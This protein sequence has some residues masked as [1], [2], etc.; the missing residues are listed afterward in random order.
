MMGV[1]ILVTGGAGFIGSH[2]ADALLREG[3]HV[4]VLDDFSTGR[5]ANLPD[6]HERLE[7][8]RGC[9]TDAPG[10]RDACAGVDGVVHLAA[11]ASVQ[12]SVDDPVHTHEVNFRGTLNV[13]EGM[14]AAGAR[15][16]VYASSAAVYGNRCAPPVAEDITLQPLTPYASDKLAGEHYAEFYAREFGLEPGVFRFFNVY[17]PRQ[18]PGS[19][20][21]GVISIFF[22]RLLRGAPVTIFGDGG[23]TRDFVYVGDVV[24]ILTASVLSGSPP[25]AGAV[26]VGTGDATSI[27]ELYRMVQG[28]VGNRAAPSYAAPRPGEVRESRADVSRLRERMA[29]LVPDTPVA[30]G[31]ARLHGY[32]QATIGRTCES[33]RPAATGSSGS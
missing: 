33:G 6:G 28:L 2:V 9:V 29:A 26:N 18:D 23:Q 3:C 30:A 8:L 12:A 5:M 22:D 7:V 25:A 20:Y 14:R 27:N 13:L 21:S 10:V 17:G 15:R 32:L 4:R 11:V 1:R 16:L 24:R 19:P 31:L